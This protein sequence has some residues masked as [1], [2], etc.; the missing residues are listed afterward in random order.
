M[1][2]NGSLLRVT[3]I[4]QGRSLSELARTVRIDKGTLSKVER[5][6]E[7]LSPERMR[8][9]AIELGL[10]MDRVAPELA[11]LRLEAERR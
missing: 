9:L 1:K 3:R 10:P 8:R 4:E 7:G 11:Q 6:Q 2:A 5:E